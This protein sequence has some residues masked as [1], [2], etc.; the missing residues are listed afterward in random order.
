[1]ACNA[2]SLSDV[3]QA[4][5][6]IAQQANALMLKIR[7]FICISLSRADYLASRSQM[8]ATTLRLHAAAGAILR[9]ERKKKPQRAVR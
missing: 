5:R 4:A 8:C 7:I 2:S 9:A 3:A 1:L 6:L